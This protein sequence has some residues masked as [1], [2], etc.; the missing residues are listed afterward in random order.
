MIKK[1]SRILLLVAALMLF[2]G[3]ASM[4]FSGVQPAAAE[5]YNQL[6]TVSIPTVTSSPIGPYITVNLDQD[7]VNV[8]SGPSTLY[9]KVGVLLAGQTAPAKGRNGDWILI[10]YA[11]VPTGTAWI[12]GPLVTVSGGALPIVEP[13]PTPTPLVTATIDA[14]LAAQFV[15]SPEVTRLPTFTSAPTI[16][17]PKFSDDTG[18][19]SLPV[20]WV[21][22]FIGLLG[23][24]LGLLS[25]LQ[26]R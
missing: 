25:L 26:S 2:W 21:I 23:I 18:G 16:A 1:N 7:Q 4:L 24:I 11:G 22:L 17:I 14:T 5:M 12:Y 20:G 13:P 9:P 15:T 8:R 6:P 3:G 10:D 19:G